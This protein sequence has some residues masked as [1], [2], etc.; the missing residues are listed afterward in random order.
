MVVA[1]LS[2]FAQYVELD[3]SAFE[4]YRPVEMF[5]RTKFPT[6]GKTPYVLTLAPH[7]FY[8]FEMERHQ[9]LTA[10]SDKPGEDAVAKVI[11]Q[12]LG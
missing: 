9:A 8:W 2:R 7:G 5:G 3:L 11:P 6:I 1:N 12:Q 4:G 10:L